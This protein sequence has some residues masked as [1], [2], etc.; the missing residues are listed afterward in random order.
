M[1]HDTLLAV[2]AALLAPAYG[3][4]MMRFSCSKLVIERLD[5]LVSPGVAQSPH[6]HQVG[7]GNSFRASMPT[8]SEGDE[9]EEGIRDGDGE[10]V[11]LTNM[12]RR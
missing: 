12:W 5:P 8:G 6:L 10:S 11:L 4:Q 1:R 9:G 2:A 3:Q 7:G